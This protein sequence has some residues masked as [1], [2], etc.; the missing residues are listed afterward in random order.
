MWEP[1]AFP[2]TNNTVPLLPTTQEIRAC[3]TILRERSTAK[4]VAINDEII[5]K[6]GGGVEYLGRLS[7]VFLV[8]QRAPGVQLDVAWPT[9]KE[10]EKASI[11]ATLSNIFDSMRIVECPWP[12]FFGL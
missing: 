3:A 8:M 9:L 5:V 1:V 2:F 6:F 12:N 4:V 7:I 10:S 11:T